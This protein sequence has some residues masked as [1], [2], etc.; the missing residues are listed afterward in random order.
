MSQEN[1]EIVRRLTSRG[2]KAMR[3]RD[4]EAWIEC[5]HPEAEMLMPRNLLEGGNYK[6][7]DG[8]RQAFED[9]FKTWDDLRVEVEDIRPLDDGALLLGHSV[10]VGKGNAPTIEFQSAFLIKLR[11]GKVSYCRPYQS[12]AEA[13]EAAGLSE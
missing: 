5:F 11:D 12:H 8:L 9:A 10:N 7:H 4:V 1:V 13:L 6:G 3:E 2:L